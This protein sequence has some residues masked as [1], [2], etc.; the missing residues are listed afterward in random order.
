MEVW[1]MGNSNK[2]V[3]GIC[4]QTKEGG[5]HIYQLYIC[6]ACEEEIL[7]VHPKDDNYQYYVEKM[8]AINQI[9]YTI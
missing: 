4:N 5:I 1:Q 8:R 3:C 9:T 2:H 7:S 6:R